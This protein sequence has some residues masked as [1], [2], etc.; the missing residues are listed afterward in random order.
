MNTYFTE[1]QL[2]DLFVRGD[3]Q[4]QR[5]WSGLIRAIFNPG[6]LYADYI[7]ERTSGAGVTID[8]V[9]IK[10]GTVTTTAPTVSSV[11]P[12]ITAHAGGTKAAAY[13]LSKQINI[14]TT[15]AT[16]LDSLL[17]PTAVVG[18][19]I[20]VAN[21][22]VATCAIYGKG[23]NTIDDIATANP[24]ILQPEDVVTFTCYTTAKWQSDSEAVSA[25]DKIYVD[26]ISENTAAAGVTIDGVIL[27]DG[28]ISVVTPG[29]LNLSSISAGT[30]ATPIVDANASDAF[31]VTINMSTAVN[32]TGAGDSCMGAYVKVSNTANGTN[33]RLQGVL[34][35]TS[36]AFD[37]YDAYGL[38]SNMTIGAGAVATGNLTAVSGKVVVSDAVATGIISAG[39][40]TLEGA[41]NPAA[42]TYGVWIDITAGITA[43]SGLIINNNASTCTNGINLTGT[44]TSHITSSVAMITDM[45]VTAPGV[46]FDTA[47]GVLYMPYG[48]KNI[49]GMYYEEIFVDLN[50]A[51]V[52]GVGTDGDA[53]GEAAGGAAHIG[54]ITAALNGTVQ[55]IEV[56]CVE[57][58]TTGT[59]DINLY[60][61]ASG[62]I[63]YGD[64]LGGGTL[65]VDAGGNWTL[66]MVKAANNLPAANHYLYLGEGD[67]AGAGAYATGKFIIKIWGS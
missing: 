59:A 56:I 62:A 18:Q 33:T 10:D 41:F 54:Q 57:A 31:A 12:A 17:M 42:L 38:Q 20:T 14:V 63:P 39:L 16:A 47:G 15:C 34:A 1:D 24:F 8:G 22:G 35:A 5:M 66:G 45:P 2:K 48:K 13:A 44:F 9:L 51:A 27:K 53:I 64:A 11:D 4:Q 25:Y 6:T 67:G 29:G 60:S 21:L 55:A 36:V 40:F 52:S 3:H 43:D 26:T 65:L 28:R 46:G 58:P 49:T 19:Q 37:C 7:Y 50:T 30:Y 61:N 32:K 23:T